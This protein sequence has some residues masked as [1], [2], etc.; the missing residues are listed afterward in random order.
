MRK[1][2]EAS[3]A[4]RQQIFQLVGGSAQNNDSD[5]A[6]SYSVLIRKAVIDR[7]Q[8]VEAR[9]FCCIK[10]SPVLQAT[11]A[12]ADGS[13]PVVVREGAAEASGDAFIQ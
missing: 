10:Q 1:C 5:A 3:R 6:M 4:K 8:G 11:K 2:F 9:P 12:S 7:D 13:V